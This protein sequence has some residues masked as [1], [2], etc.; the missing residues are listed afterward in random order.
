MRVN[1]NAL[2]GS[3]FIA[4][5]MVVFYHYARDLPG[6]RQWASHRLLASGPEAVSYFFCLSGFIMALVYAPRAVEKFDLK[7]FYVARFARIYPV[8]LLAFLWSLHLWPGRT[9]PATVGL[10][11]LLLQ[12][13]VPGYALDL[14]GPAWSLSTEAFFYVVFP[15][16]LRWLYPRKAAALLWIGL[17]FWVISQVSFV[18]LS[19]FWGGPFMSPSSNFLS[20]S[21]VF[22]FNAFLLGVAVGLIVERGRH[23]LP[24]WTGWRA[25]VV[26]VVARYLQRHPVNR[27][28]QQVEHQR[29]RRRARNRFQHLQFHLGEDG[30]TAGRGAVFASH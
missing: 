26:M 10:G 7:G 11:A 22:H 1:L 30:L 9:Y 27:A 16:V 12:S 23:R 18:F 6:F 4:A 17:L 15:W 19:S 8:Y 29:R 25:E 13:W 28:A 21:P 24:Q 2:T 20:Y 3:R 14:N 5:L